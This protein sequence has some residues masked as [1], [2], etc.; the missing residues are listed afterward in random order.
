[1]SSRRELRSA[2]RPLGADRA[3]GDARGGAAAG[4]RKEKEDETLPTKP[5]TD[6]KQPTRRVTRAMTRQEGTADARATATT[7]SATLRN[8][9]AQLIEAGKQCPTEDF[10]VCTTVE[11]ET[12]REAMKQLIQRG[13]Q[14]TEEEVRL[15]SGLLETSTDKTEPESQDA[16]TSGPPRRNPPRNTRRQD[17]QS[18]AEDT[19]EDRPRDGVVEQAEPERPHPFAALVSAARAPPQQDYRPPEHLTRTI[20]STKQTHKAE[21]HIIQL[22]ANGIGATEK[23]AEI[24]RYAEKQK[25]DVLCLQE[26][27]LRQGQETPKFG[28]WEVAAR[29]DRRQHRGTHAGESHGYGGV[30]TLVRRGC[31]F[32][33]EPIAYDVRDRNS[34]AVMTDI[35]STTRTVRLLNAYIATV[36]PSNEDTRRDEFNPDSL[37]QGRNVIIAADMNAHH[38]LWDSNRARDPRGGRIAEWMDQHDMCV[39]N[40]GA[41]TRHDAS[42]RGTYTRRHNLPCRPERRD[43]VEYR[44]RPGVGPPPATHQGGDASQDAAPSKEK[45]ETVPAESKLDTVP[46]TDRPQ[47]QTQA[48]PH[49]MDR[50]SDKKTY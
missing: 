26:T 25:A 34:D 12:L 3:S 20:R 46:N 15:D 49:D 10:Q 24:L 42:G 7:E 29:A 6:T 11:A 9:M 5:E 35:Q 28:G 48:T 40:S 37:P 13:K 27:N 23:R 14:C 17:T 18:P 21:L 22:N 33:F 2:S 31:G 38:E 19:R 4:H 30:L 32:G 43:R 47:I 36:K 1:M 41:P 45:S 39:L 44:G 50:G 16:P 8:V